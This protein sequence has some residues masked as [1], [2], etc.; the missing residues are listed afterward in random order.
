M[1]VRSGTLKA[2]DD[3][4]TFMMNPSSTSRTTVD[5]GATIDLAGNSQN[6]S[7]ADLQG[8]GTVTNSS[9]N[10]ASLIINST[11]FSGTFSGALDLEVQTSS[12][13]SG[14]AAN[15][16]DLIIDDLATVTNTGT[17]D[18]LGGNQLL[19]SA[20]STTPTS[21]F[22]NDGLFKQSGLGAGRGNAN[23]LVTTNFVNNGTLT[24]LHGS[25]DFSSSFTNIVDMR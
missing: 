8:A 17:Y 9:S 14:L 13:F 5:A 1:E 11:N 18:F 12:L 19:D 20:D 15:D 4:F 3:D 7:I 25:L 10:S 6:F 2:A 23:G 21:T 22:V 24:V 16:G